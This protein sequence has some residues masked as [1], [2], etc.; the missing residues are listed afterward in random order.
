MKLNYR[1]FIIQSCASRNIFCESHF[2]PPCS[3]SQPDPF[4]LIARPWRILY[5]YFL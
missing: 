1:Q 3:S 4:Y 2:F 5:F